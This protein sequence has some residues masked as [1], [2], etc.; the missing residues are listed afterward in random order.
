MDERAEQLATFGQVA[1]FGNMLGYGFSF[2]RSTTEPP[3]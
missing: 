3:W 2:R 1:C